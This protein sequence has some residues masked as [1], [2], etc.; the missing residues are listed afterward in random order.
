ME[1]GE[2]GAG[3]VVLT[4]VADFSNRAAR[5]REWL[6]FD[7]FPRNGSSQGAKSILGANRKCS[8]GR[9]FKPAVRDSH[10]DPDFAS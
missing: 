8:G 6:V 9:G 4:L 2:Y 3:F 7:G 10:G 5:L 1:R